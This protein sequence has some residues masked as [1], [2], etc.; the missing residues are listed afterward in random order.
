MFKNLILIP[1]ALASSAL[2]AE[3]INKSFFNQAKS[4]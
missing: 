4:Q 2:V 3:S 1:T